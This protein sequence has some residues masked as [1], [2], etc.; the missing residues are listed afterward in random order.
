MARLTLK[1][2]ANMDIGAG[3]GAFVSS[4]G[5]SAQLTPQGWISD[6]GE[7]LAPNAAA[8]QFDM[9][10]PVDYMG[11]RGYMQMDRSIVDPSGNVIYESQDAVKQRQAKDMARRQAEKDALD[12]ELKR[13]QIAKTRREATNVGGG[14]V[15]IPWK[16]DAAS[17]EFVAPPTPEFPQGRRSGNLAKEGARKSL[18]YVVGQFGTPDS[19]GPLQK[20]PQGGPLGITGLVGKVTNSQD[21]KRFNNLKEQLS[22]EL[23]T[24][25][26]IPG[27]GALSDK[28]QA[29]Y[30]IQLPDVTNDQETNAAILRDIQA[31]V[32]ARLDTGANPLQAAPSVSDQG[33]VIN[34][35][36]QQMLVLSRNADGS[37]RI[38][39]PRTGR[40]GTVRP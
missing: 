27:E 31:R 23:R 13:S 37:I 26:R 34:V 22:T 36:G 25:F 1:D 18:D 14:S 6:S 16:Y 8:P 12:A 5:T 33:A 30:G 39:D 20:T 15:E 40:T 24:L 38:R 29:Q 4:R 2:L 11:R 28:E 17:D 35:G 19:P 10:Q 3:H 7:I 9:R 32:A 21:A